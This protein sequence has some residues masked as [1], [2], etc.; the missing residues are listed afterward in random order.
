MNFMVLRMKLIDHPEGGGI[1]FIGAQRIGMLGDS[2]RFKASLHGFRGDGT[3]F[4]TTAF[5]QRSKLT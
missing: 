1:A 4:T 3:G 5:D 2:K